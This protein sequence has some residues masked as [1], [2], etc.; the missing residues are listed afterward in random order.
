MN[1]SKNTQSLGCDVLNDGCA[2]TQAETIREKL[3]REYHKDALARMKPILVNSDNLFLKKILFFGEGLSSGY[4]SESDE[5]N[6]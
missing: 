1:C 5:D 4:V 2:D 6:N 3:D